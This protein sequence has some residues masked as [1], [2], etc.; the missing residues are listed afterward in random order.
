MKSTLIFAVFMLSTLSAWAGQ[1][2]IGTISDPSGDDFGSGTLVYP[3]RSDYLAGDLDLIQLD[4]SRDEEGF[5]FEAKFKNPIRDPRNASSSAGGESLENF[6]RKGFYQFNLDIYVDTDHVPGS[7]NTFTL[8]GRQVHIDPAYAWEKA[9][10]LTPRPELMR[11]QLLDAIAEQYPERSTAG[12]QAGIDQAMYFPTRIRASGKSISFFVPASFFSGSEE[13]SWGVTAFVTGAI[14][15][16]PSDLIFIPSTKKPL[17]RLQLGVMQPAPGHPADSFGYKPGGMVPSPVV[18]LLGSSAEQQR[19]QLKAQG[20]LVG[21]NIGGG[22]Q[23]FSAGTERDANVAA[24]EIVAHPTVSMEGLFQPD[25]PIAADPE[26]SANGG[27]A[28]ASI[29]KR[30]QILQQL[31]D[32]RLIDEVE[33]KE[34]KQRILKEL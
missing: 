16:I 33:C 15:A 13:G 11:Q 3:Q 8:P 27:E 34:Q 12:T 19:G 5:W 32:Q 25:S 28:G 30:L 31:Y 6:T 4:I 20:K 9:V 1:Q 29:V 18:D 22:D 23:K 2:S 10:I 24:A 17:E 7:G 26:T 21:V 14:T